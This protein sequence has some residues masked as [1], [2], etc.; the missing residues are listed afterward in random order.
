MRSSRQSGLSFLI[1]FLHAA[2][3]GF[4]HRGGLGFLQQRVGRLVVQRDEV[5]VHRFQALLGLFAVDDLHRPLDDGQGPQAEEVELHQAGRLH[6]VL[7]ELG[8]QA[9][10]FL[11]AGD[12]REVGQLGRRDHH[13]TG[14]LAGTTGDAFQLEGHLPDFG[15]FLVA[16]EEVAEHFFLLVGFFQGHADFER[17]H[18]R[19]PVGEAVGL[20]LDPGHVAHHRLRRHGAEGDDLADRVAPV[21]IGHVVD[22]PVAAFHAE[23]DV[24]VGHGDPFR[25]EET[26]EQQVVGQRVEVG[27]LQHVGHQRAGARAPPG[28][29]RHAVVLRP[30]DEVHHDEEVTGEAHLDDDVELEVQTVDVDLAPGL[31]VRGILRQQ[32]LQALLEAFEGSVPQVVVDTHAIGRGKVRQ[33]VLAQL[34]LDVAALGDLHGVLQRLGEVAE[35]L[36]HFRR[37]LQVLLV[38]IG[39]RPPRIVESPSLA[40]ADAGL[41]GLEVFL[42]DEAHVVGRHQ[43]RIAA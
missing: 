1:S 28:A 16:L 5:D 10:A 37:R 34:H 14:V 21:G 18:L 31:V 35:Q 29:Y 32:H 20:A 19:Q 13:A 33:E 27:D 6:V 42:P 22:H 17:D 2:R 7:V 4:E 24:E 38:R 39:A 30:L 43:R 40:D 3:F 41:V 12:R 36:G 23:V 15:G 9:A 26:F 8:H 25:V 11:V